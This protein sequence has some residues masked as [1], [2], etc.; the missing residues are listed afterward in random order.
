[1]TPDGGGEVRA[2]QPTSKDH[3]TN[4][5]ALPFLWCCLKE[6]LGKNML[7]SQSWEK[8]IRRK[9][10]LPKAP[11]KYFSKRLRFLQVISKK[12]FGR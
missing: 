10:P 2:P 11:A 8:Q 1:M 6:N 12:A 5:C 3:N 7:W 4:H 9:W